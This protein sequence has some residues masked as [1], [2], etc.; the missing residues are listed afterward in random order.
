MN[1]WENIFN[2]L[3]V[4]PSS[5]N[6]SINDLKKEST[7]RSLSQLQDEIINLKNVVIELIL[8]NR[9]N[10]EQNRKLLELIISKMR[11]LENI[12]EPEIR[13]SPI[14][15]SYR[16]EVLPELKQ[17]SKINS[18]KITDLNNIMEIVGSVTNSFMNNIHKK[19]DK[20]DKS[21][22]QTNN[23]SCQN[24]SNVIEMILKS[25]KDFNNIDKKEHKD[26]NKSEEQNFDKNNSLNTFD[27]I[28]KSLK[29]INNIRSEQERHK[30]TED[31]S[32]ISAVIEDA[33]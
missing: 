20:D 8:E 17:T 33:D 2:I 13:T 9:K 16:S 7:S 22:E 18:N 1:N 6:Y 3:G 30:N 29:D 26:E 25:L 21:E 15:K 4:E 24:S 14:K 27:L 23:S 19:Q 12:Q 32:S 10:Q 5:Y 31:K 28:I 11:L